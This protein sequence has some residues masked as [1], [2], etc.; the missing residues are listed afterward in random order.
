MVVL[1]YI[2]GNIGA[3]KS[4]IIS[5][6]SKNKNVII[7]GENV[8]FG[9]KF[10]DLLAKYYAEP[11]KYAFEFQMSYLIDK[12]TRLLGAINSANNRV[13]IVERGLYSD[14]IFEQMHYELGNISELDHQ[15]YV[16]EYTSMVKQL[17][18]LTQSQL[19]FSINISPEECLRRI[20]SRNRGNES[21]KITLNYLQ[22][23][24]KIAAEVLSKINCVCADGPTI[25]QNLLELI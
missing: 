22:K 15:K 7:L 9:E 13:I 16:A 2:N 4:T 18:F 5:K 25:A 10:G 6:L 23:Y 19:H 24:N 8:E 1:I 17:A 12:F 14:A 20:V 3:G 11:K 21:A